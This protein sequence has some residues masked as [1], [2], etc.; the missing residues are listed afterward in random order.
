MDE[1]GME[2]K[3]ADSIAQAFIRVTQGPDLGRVITIAE[4]VVLGRI[5]SCQVVLP[6]PGASRRHAQILKTD[7]GYFLEDLKSANGTFLNQEKI[8]RAPLNEGD[9][10]RI[11]R[12]EYKFGIA[13]TGQN[14]A[15]TN[16]DAAAAHT[17]GR[18][19]ELQPVPVT[20]MAPVDDSNTFSVVMDDKDD[21]SEDQIIQKAVAVEEQNLAQDV[22]TA[23]SQED[24]E[25]VSRRL[26]IITEVST[27]ISTILD[28]QDLLTSVMDRLFDVLPNSGRGYILLLDPDE[29][30]TLKSK[31]QKRRDEEDTSDIQVSLT[32]VKRAIRQKEAILYVGGEG[33]ESETSASL[34]QFNIRSMMCVPLICQNEV[35]GVI[36]IDT[37]DARYKFTEEDLQLLTA[38][39]TPVATAVRNTQLVA[40][41]ESEVVTRNALQQFFSPKLVEKIISGGGNLDGETREGIAFFSDLVGFTKMSSNIPAK[42]MVA[43]LNKY[44][45]VM[46]E[47]LFRHDATIDKFSGDAI[48]AIWGAPEEVENGAWHA[49][50]SGLEMQNALFEFN[51]HQLANDEQTVDM[52]IGINFGQFI[53]GNIGASE[54]QMV[55]YTIIG[56]DV[57][58]AAR[59]EARAGWGQVFISQSAFEKAEESICG[60]KLPPAE[61]KGVEG[62]KIIYSI[63][64]C[65]P[66]EGGDEGEFITTLPV[67]LNA[68]DFGPVLA[69]LVKAKWS[70]MGKNIIF[71]FIVPYTIEEGTMVNVAFQMNELGII[72]D[73]KGTVI[74]FTRDEEGVERNPQS[75]RLLIQELPIILEDLLHP[76]GVL[77]TELGW[78]SMERG[79][80][81]DAIASLSS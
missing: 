13:G 65:T 73:V 42:D 50:Q 58:M 40:E 54:R 3:M 41:K 72:P 68:D 16:Q 57:N 11:C 30:G 34:M 37:S 71:D 70:D 17:D 43:L 4:D 10:I 78:E 48:M 33:G 59:I 20:Q 56:D 19:G 47:I 32:M 44:F 79:N 5:P 63:R 26:Q 7:E 77:E 52:G 53:A 75:G 31:V 66:I 6:D 74:Q 25:R 39:A 15:I 27:E 21:S 2:E 35:L 29:P 23:K 69:F 64:A 24:L 8:Q 61:L 67:A 36:D 45:E 38:I 49:A 76:G 81:T 62:D 12:L 51:C 1:I 28:L 55:N 60:V 14:P 9:L 22:L 80:S 18:V 46:V